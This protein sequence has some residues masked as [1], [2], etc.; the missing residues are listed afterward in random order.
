[1]MAT[2]QTLQ[3]VITSSDGACEEADMNEGK[4]KQNVW[5]LL[6]HTVWSLQRDVTTKGEKYQKN[7]KKTKVIVKIANRRDIIFFG[8]IAVSIS[9]FKCS[10]K[11]KK[12]AKG[13]TSNDRPPGTQ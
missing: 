10:K 2:S 11:K 7:K 5:E 13:G 4:S 8:L 12:S 6:V 1:M 9:A 3:N